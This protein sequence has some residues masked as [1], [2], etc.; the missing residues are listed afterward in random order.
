MISLIKDLIINANRGL[1][2]LQRCFKQPNQIPSFRK[3][4]HLP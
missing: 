4:F 3:I 1:F 2:D